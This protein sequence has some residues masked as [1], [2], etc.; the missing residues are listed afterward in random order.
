MIHLIKRTGG[1]MA[2]AM[3]AA[4]IISAVSFATPAYADMQLAQ[5]GQAP[6]P[7]ATPAPPN[8]MP[9]EPA[10]RIESRIKSLHDQLQITS[11]QESQWAAV[12]QAMRDSANQM[13]TL[14]QQRA[15]SAMSMTAVDDLRSYQAI[16]RAHLEG[17]NKLVPAFETLY[18]SMSDTQ[19]KNADTVFKHK[20]RGA[21]KKSG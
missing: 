17:L 2:V 16:A 7:G 12:A 8:A 1:I 13:K 10:D 19:K 21:P 3:M 5:A 11:A 18:A 20:P 6:P 4:M 9:P 15:Q 14:V